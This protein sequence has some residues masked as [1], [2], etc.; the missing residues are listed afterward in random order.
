MEL[1]S[2]L[3]DTVGNA[4]EE[5]AGQNPTNLEVV[6][7]AL[8]TVRRFLEENEGFAEPGADGEVCTVWFWSFEICT[9]TQWNMLKC[10][11]YFAY[12]SMY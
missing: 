10:S 12:M 3:R 2:D 1:V 9:C 11:V 4:A 6:D 7:E 5:G 8:Q